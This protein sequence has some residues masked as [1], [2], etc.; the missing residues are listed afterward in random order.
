VAWHSASIF[1]VRNTLPLEC[2]ISS[3]TIAGGPK[4]VDHPFPDFTTKLLQV[5]LIVW[6]L[7]LPVQS[8]QLQNTKGDDLHCE[9]FQYDF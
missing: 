2:E 8:V 5:V 3:G 6:L 1:N 4:K 9:V 7:A